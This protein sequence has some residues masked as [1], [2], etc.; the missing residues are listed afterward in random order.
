MDCNENWGSSS[1]FSDQ[2]QMS[3]GK[4]NPTQ[5]SLV[6]NSQLF[7]QSIKHFD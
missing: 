7:N 2:I 6:K 5:I 1:D 3:Q 4:R